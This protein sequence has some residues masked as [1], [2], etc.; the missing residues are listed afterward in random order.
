MNEKLRALESQLEQRTQQLN[1]EIMA[2]EELKVKA[3]EL[4][5]KVENL[6]EKVEETLNFLPE[7]HPARKPEV[8]E[9]KKLS[10]K[11]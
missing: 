5:S 2:K 6:E 3:V 11:G 4:T 10:R 8:E 1:S 7:N 9:I